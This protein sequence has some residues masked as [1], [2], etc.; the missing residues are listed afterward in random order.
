MY[1][2]CTT[3][4]LGSY[5][6]CTTHVPRMYLACTWLWSGFEMTLG[7]LEAPNGQD[8]FSVLRIPTHWPGLEE[9]INWS[10]GG[11]QLVGRARAPHDLASLS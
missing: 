2:A 3:L 10:K 6:A 5:L 8:T 1:H 7:G 11:V 4:A 9:G